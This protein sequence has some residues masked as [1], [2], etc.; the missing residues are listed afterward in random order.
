MNVEMYKSYERLSVKAGTVIFREKDVADV[1][2]VIISGR[3][4]ISKQIM[5]GVDKTLSVLEEGEYFGEMSLLLNANRTA[6]VTAIEDT[7]LIKLEL[8][9]FKQIL[10]D[11]PNS[12]IA[13]LI[14]LAS[15][16]DKVTKEAIFLSLEL[17]LV[18][19]KPPEYASIPGQQIIVATGSFEIKDM[20]E[21]LH[22]RKDVQWSPQTKILL[23]LFKPGQG[24]N[25]LIYVIQTK[26]IH[27]TMRLTSCFKELVQWTFSPAVS[28]EDEFLDTLI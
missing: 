26:D 19:Q 20:S 27:E 6:T 7:E 8:D 12:G 16:L 28:T 23:S 9:D 14:Q 21:I 22:R 4:T 13:M 15:R 3:V 5:P 1:M 24:Q 10:K 11:H 25:A 18:E 2:Y 17:A